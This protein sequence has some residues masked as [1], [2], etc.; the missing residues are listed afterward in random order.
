M[1]RRGGRGPG[2]QAA[3]A[4]AGLLRAGPDARALADGYL[5]HYY[6]FLGDIAGQIASGAAVSPEMVQGYAAGF[7]QA[8]CDELIF[9][10]A[11]SS[12]EQVGLLADAVS[13]TGR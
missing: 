11:S 3:Q 8:G 9:V 2:G 12:L 7:A 10:P 5:G 4:I 6:A 13:L 1:T